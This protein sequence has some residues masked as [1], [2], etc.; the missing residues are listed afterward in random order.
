MRAIE[1]QVDRASLGAICAKLP[2]ETIFAKFQ[3]M[4]D[5]GRT[6]ILDTRPADLGE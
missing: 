5:L 4:V 2:Q 6:E 1:W 3:E